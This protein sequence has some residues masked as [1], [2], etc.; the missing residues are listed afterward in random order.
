MINQILIINTSWPETLFDRYNIDTLSTLKKLNT[1]QRVL[2]FLLKKINVFSLKYVEK[3]DWHKKCPGYE[4]IILFDKV[5]GS[6]RLSKKVEESVSSKTRLVY[7][8]LNPVSYSKDLDQIT[9]RWEKWTFSKQDSVD[10]NFKYGETFYFN[11]LLPETNNYTIVYDTLFVGLDKGRMSYL[12]ELK[13]YFYRH[14]ITPLFYIVDNAKS[15]L[16][17]NYYRRLSYSKVVELVQQSKSITDVVQDKQEGMTLRVME[18][19]FFSKKL[20]TNNKA[21]KNRE[22]YFKENVFILGEDQNIE[23]FLKG[24]F[25]K[26]DADLVN[27]YEF[28]N[29]INR[30]QRNK[31]F[32]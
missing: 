30:I 8:M 1:I 11:E 25:A 13:K 9:S 18:S 19:I 26:L 28:S 29:W 4:I 7:F 2:I 6:S 31:E 14:G 12:E 24:S 23:E 15:L 22:I 17:R 20:I 32:N 16:S 3:K 10:Y 27:K 5:K 21:I